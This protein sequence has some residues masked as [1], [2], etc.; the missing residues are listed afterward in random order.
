MKDFPLLTSED[1]EVKIKQVTKAGA[2]ALLYKT[3]RVDRKILNKVF[4]PLN[5]TSDY[6]VVKDNLYCGIGIR[7]DDKHDFVWKWDC[8]IE[9]R[10]DDEGNEKKGEASD[11]FKRAGFQVGIGEEL[12]T[13][14]FIWLSVATEQQNGKWRL[15]D[16]YAK[17]IVT[18]IAYNEETRVITELDICNAKTSVMVY[19]YRMPT[20]GAMAKKMVETISTP[21][22]PAKTEEPKDKT[23]AS[24]N[25][26]KKEKAKTKVVK[27]EPAVVNPIEKKKDLRTLVSGIG[28]IVKKMFETDGNADR[29]NQIIKEVTGDTTFKCNKATEEDYDTVLAIYNKLAS[30]EHNG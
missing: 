22:A 17:Y 16:P 29:Y 18:H 11:A 20:T 28:H 13:A 4:G 19:S 26:V 14:P 23:V 6:K 1:I 8:G 7:E 5:W 27:E 3:A 2:L 24:T 30:G 9:S 25:T 21:A 10:S 12:Y 15:A